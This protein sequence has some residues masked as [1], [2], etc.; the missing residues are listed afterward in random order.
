MSMVK[1]VEV[2]FTILASEDTMA[3]ARAA[4]TRPF[5]PGGI[6]VLISHG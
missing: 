3:A 4:T 1:M 6:N 5:I 2:E